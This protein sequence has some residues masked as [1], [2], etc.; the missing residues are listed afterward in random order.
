[1]TATAFV[2][3]GATA[4]MFAGE[5][6]TFQ[7]TVKDAAGNLVDIQ[8]P[9]YRYNF[10]LRLTPDAAT[11]LKP[12]TN[13]VPNGT[14]TFQVVFASNDTKTFKAG[15]YWYG[16]ARNNAGAFDVEAQG[17]FIIYRAAVHAP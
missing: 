15:T 5:D 3:I 8:A 10:S 13:I 1:M 16:V 6:K 4:E 17:K 9:A 7:F 14:N 11:D 12:V 2:D